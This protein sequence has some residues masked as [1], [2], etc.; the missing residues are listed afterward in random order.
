MDLYNLIKRLD[1]YFVE[2]NSVLSEII[3]G[4]IAGKDSTINQLKIN[5]EHINDY[6]IKFEKEYASLVTNGIDF[7]KS[8][9][10]ILYVLFLSLQIEIL[11]RHSK[12]LVDTKL[13]QSK[14][15]EIFDMILHGGLQKNIRPQNDIICKIM[16]EIS[17][18]IEHIKCSVLDK[19]IELAFNNLTKTGIIVYNGIF[20]FAKFLYVIVIE[21]CAK[22]S[23][24]NVKKLITQCEQQYS[25][26]S[27]IIDYSSF[28][29]MFG[30]YN[31]YFDQDQGS[32]CHCL[33]KSGTLNG[34]EFADQE[35]LEKYI[36][37]KSKSVTFKTL[38][39][40]KQIKMLEEILHVKLIIL[41][42]YAKYEGSGSSNLMKHRDQYNYELQNT[43]SRIRIIEKF[44]R[45]PPK[46]RY[47]KGEKKY[48]ISHEHI[49]PGIVTLVDEF[50][51]YSDESSGSMYKYKEALVTKREILEVQQREISDGGPSEEL[52]KTKSAIERIV[53]GKRDLIGCKDNPIIITDSDIAS[54]T[55]NSFIVISYISDDIFELVYDGYGHGQSQYCQ[56]EAIP[57]Y[58]RIKWILHHS[59][60]KIFY[61][62]NTCL[63]CYSPELTKQK[64]EPIAF[65]I[66]PTF[67][68]IQKLSSTLNQIITDNLK[69]SIDFTDKVLSLIKSSQSDIK[70]IFSDGINNF[71]QRESMSLKGSTF[72]N[73]L[74]TC[75]EALGY[76][77]LLLP[78]IT[79]LTTFLQAHSKLLND[80]KAFYGMISQMKK[81]IV[82]TTQFVI[83]TLFAEQKKELLPNPDIVRHVN[84]MIVSF[85][86]FTY[87]WFVQLLID[88]FEEKYQ[89]SSTTEKRSIIKTLFPMIQNIVISFEK[90]IIS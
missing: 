70:Q 72:S 65:R 56:F 18:Q 27:G 9:D 39:I 5:S 34:I 29:Q 55:V 86:I 35:Q 59:Y 73:K 13:F 80:N 1:S 60:P 15:D 52:M 17:Q 23:E 26:Q 85:H 44:I 66:T 38:N 19:M 61:N 77:R 33:A 7:E 47:I 32:I 57:N 68:K 71:V 81:D 50:I 64:R 22:K 62:K 41:N 36:Q 12:N 79:K 45:F 49:E 31:I 2:S 28:P 14:T 40:N 10:G 37:M 43:W 88:S 3:N 78:A 69:I 51:P 48:Q 87:R 6:L 74:W 8:Q 84:E 54:L 89:M 63:S 11:F 42:K 25:E 30:N 16:L 4:I 76:I 67:D 46:P 21:K 90:E 24:S 83:V 53:I 75:E 82:I 20:E 58:P